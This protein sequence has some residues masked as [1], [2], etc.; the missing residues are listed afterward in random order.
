M[1]R[2]IGLFFLVGC[3]G[4][5]ATVSDSTSDV[6]EGRPPVEVEPVK[7]AEPALPTTSFECKT[8]KALSDGSIHTIRFALRGEALE[9]T[10]EIE[11]QPSVLTPLASATLERSE[12]KLVLTTTERTELTLFENSGLTRGYVKAPRGDY[13]DVYCTKR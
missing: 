3:S 9:P 6:S 8:S 11:P 5:G 12:G 13:S 2:L 10:I 1:K 4:S 7:Q